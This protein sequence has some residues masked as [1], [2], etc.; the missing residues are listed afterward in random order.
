VFGRG[1]IVVAVS[2]DYDADE[3]DYDNATSGLVATDVQ[4]A[5]DELAA[6]P[7]AGGWNAI[8]VKE[9]DEN[10]TTAMQD[11]DELFTS[12]AANKKYYVHLTFYSTA[13]GS[14]EFDAPASSTFTG[15][16]SGIGSPSSTSWINTRSGG[17][18]YIN[19]IVAPGRDLLTAQGPTG[20]GDAVRFITEIH[21]VLTTSTTA[22][23]LQF[24]Y[25]VTS[26]T[27]TIYAG[28]VLRIK[29][30]T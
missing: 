1:G 9:L 24:R 29:D 11:D 19:M 20:A 5:V 6:R 22:G 13:S 30:I 25:G 2:G 17:S 26:G 12:V 23:T 16:I 3:V 8:V 21:G 4:A 7:A 10:V 15:N 27:T 14:F 18:Q 28:S